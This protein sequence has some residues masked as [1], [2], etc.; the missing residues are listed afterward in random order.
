MKWSC[1]LKVHNQQIC[2]KQ[3]L[4]QEQKAIKLHERANVPFP[5][6]HQGSIADIPA[7]ESVL[8]AQVEIVSAT[9]NNINAIFHA[10]KEHSDKQ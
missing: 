3:L 5:H 8:K 4:E 6:D 2:K 7:F 9:I 10:G 1:E